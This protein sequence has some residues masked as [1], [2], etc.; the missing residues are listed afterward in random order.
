MKKNGLGSCNR[1]QLSA[2]FVR[3]ALLVLL[4]LVLV[5][6]CVVILNPAPKASN[7]ITVD[8]LDDPGN[9]S[10]C[11]LRAA[12]N[13]ANNET[14]DSNSTCAAGIGNDAIV[15]SVTGTIGLNSALPAIA[16]TLTIDGSGQSITVDGGGAY[17][18]FYINSTATV[19]LN[20]LT[21]ANGYASKS[22]LGSE[23]GGGAYN[24]GTLTVSNSTFS[25]NSALVQGGAI[26]N[27]N[28]LT[29]ANSTFTGDST[30]TSGAGGAILSDGTESITN[31]TFSNNS[32]G[33]G[34]AIVSY[35]FDT[36][37]ISGSTFSGNSAS[38]EGYGGAIVSAG[39]LSITNSTFS[40]NS[41]PVSG[42]IYYDVFGALTITN[43]TF[44]GNSA[45]SGG[46]ISGGGH[47]EEPTIINSILAAYWLPARLAVIASAVSRMAATIFPTTIAAISPVP[48]PAV[49]LS[50]ITLILCSIPAGCRIMAAR[51]RLYRCN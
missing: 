4:L 36:A 21:V 8:T 27:G 45:T 48:A 50:A 1:K 13:N 34:G 24:N 16:N 40:G 5:P 2:A 28:A 9:P 35:I 18:V 37:T 10:E 47:G 6:I 33:H 43:C 22:S 41:A 38:S 7:T 29:I 30:G 26:Y 15:F 25:T 19:T 42:G 46:V 14:S 11:S 32:S 20:D 39:A 31:S 49:R 44:S 51:P 12:I 23:L 3:P 17:Q